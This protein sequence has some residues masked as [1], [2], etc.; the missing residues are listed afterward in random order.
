MRDISNKTH[1]AKHEIYSFYAKERDLG[2]IGQMRKERG[3]EEE[4]RSPQLLCLK[5]DCL[6]NF[7]NTVDLSNVHTWGCWVSERAEAG[8]GEEGQ[9]FGSRT[10]ASE[11]NGKNVAHNICLDRRPSCLNI[12]YAAPL[13]SSLW[14]FMLLLRS[15]CRRPCQINVSNTKQNHDGS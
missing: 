9:Q 4:G 10:S 6:T 13:G 5:H 8:R 1:W 2:N 7:Q 11:K 12:S 14:M 3:E 15:T